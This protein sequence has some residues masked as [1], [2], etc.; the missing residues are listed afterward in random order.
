MVMTKGKKAYIKKLTDP[1]LE[2]YFIQMDELNYTLCEELD[3]GNVKTIG[4]YSSL[5]KTLESY[6]KISM[7]KNDYSSVKEYMSEYNSLVDKIKNTFNI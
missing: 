2:P 7:V 1:V 6:C 3:S 5:G 4:Y